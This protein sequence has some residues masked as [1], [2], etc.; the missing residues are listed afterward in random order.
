MGQD[1][2]GG[3][4][5]PGP[6]G[7]VISS[8]RGTKCYRWVPRA[9]GEREGFV[10]RDGW[11]IGVLVGEKVVGLPILV[12]VIRSI[13]GTKCCRWVL[14]ALGEGGGRA[15]LRV[16]GGQLRNGVVYDDSRPLDDFTGECVSRCRPISPPPSRFGA[17]VLGP[18]WGRG[19]LWDKSGAT[20]GGG[21]CGSRLGAEET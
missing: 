3:H 11:K 1:A 6:G 14:R 21:F 5:S 20:L 2:L 7:W 17:S 13:S 19:G 12:G 8:I 4:Y 16:G 10:G 9:L 15:S 18:G